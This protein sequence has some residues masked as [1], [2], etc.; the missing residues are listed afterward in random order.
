MWGERR[1]GVSRVRHHPRREISRHRV[2][3]IIFE[4]ISR[5]TWTLL[6]SE[7]IFFSSDEEDKSW[8]ATWYVTSRE[9]IGDFYVVVRESGSGKS[10]IE[11]DLV[12]SERSFKI[13]DL[14]ETGS[15]Y[16]LCVL[17]R[18][19]EGNVKHFRSSQCRTLAHHHLLDSSSPRLAANPNLLVLIA[20]SVSRILA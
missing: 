18:D 12:Y 8:K 16:E 1:E 5:T 3:S 7:R 17:A 15:R 10:A 19:S 4:R 9:D 2:V 20:V 6:G 13:Q 14:R 11:K